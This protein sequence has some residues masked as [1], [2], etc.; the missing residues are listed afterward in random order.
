M[1]RSGCAKTWLDRLSAFEA[2]QERDV[3]VCS[4]Y[5]RLK[6]NRADNLAASHEKFFWAMRNFLAKSY[7][8]V[9]RRVP[10]SLTLPRLGFGSS[11]TQPT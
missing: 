11:L 1:R 8:V 10:L 4:G 2:A 7:R 5:R 9:R 3:A 6:A